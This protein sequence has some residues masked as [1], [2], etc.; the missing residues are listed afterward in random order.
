M[1]EAEGT[2][3]G[4]ANFVEHLK[5]LPWCKQGEDVLVAVGKATTEVIEAIRDQEVK[6]F[7]GGMT[8][9]L[10]KSMLKHFQEKDDEGQPLPVVVVWKKE[11]VEIWYRRHKSSD[12]PYDGWT[13]S[14][15]AAYERERVRIPAELMSDDYLASHADAV[16]RAKA[17]PAMIPPH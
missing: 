15:A 6:V 4:C 11:A 5:A 7:P 10:N 8:I 16:S 12:F 2:T 9:K 1:A 14:A 3:L 17:C 13:D